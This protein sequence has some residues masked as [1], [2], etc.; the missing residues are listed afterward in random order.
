M[1]R[2]L[3][4][5]LFLSLVLPLAVRADDPSLKSARNLM[6]RGSLEEAATQFETLAKTPANKSAATI[7]LSRCHEFKGRYDQALEVI[8]SALKDSP[9]D[10]PL[11]ARRA[12][13]LYL[14]GRWDDADKAAEAT[15]AI[16][17]QDV[18][19]RWV[20][21][22]LLRDRGK[23]RDADK[24]MA[25]LTRYYN[26]TE[27]IKDSDVLVIIGQAV[28][29]YSRWHKGLAEQ[30]R[31]V[32][33]DL[34]DGALK[35]DKD[36]W[37][38][39]YQAGM[40]LLEKYNRPDALEAFDKALAI[41]P[42][43]PEALVGKGLAAMEKLEL[44]EAENFAERALKVNP[45]LPEALRLIAD[46]HLF[47]GDTTAAMR[48]LETARK[49][50]PRDELTLGRVAA[51]LFLDKKNAEFDA[52]VADVSKNDASPAVFYHELGERLEERRRY[53]DAEK[54]FKKAVELRDT[55]AWPKNS[56]GMLYMRMG[57][58]KEAREI[59][60][61]AFELDPFNVRVSNTLKVLKHLDKYETLKTAHFEMRF[62]PK[63]DNALAHFI[64]GYLE[65]LYDN[66]TKQFGY[67]PKGLILIEIFTSHEM[68]SGRTVALPDLH[69]IGACTGRMFAMVSPEGWYRVSDV[70]TGKR[71]KPFN[72]ARVIDHELV[73]I[74]NLEQTNF[75]VPHWLTEGLAV[76]NEGF[77]RPQPWNTLLLAR[78]PEGKL[79]NLDN[80]DLGFMRPRTPDDWH[81]AYC[82]SNLYVEYLKKNYGEKS[83]GEM[84]AAY[85]DGLA[86]APAI[87]KVCKVDKDTFEKGYRAYLDEVIKGIKTKPPE[88]TL[89]FAQLREA[90]KKDP[91]DL[92]LKARLADAYYSRDKTQ[93]R[94]LAEEVIKDKATQPIALLV[95][96]RLEIAAG[97]SKKAF[98]LL[99]SGLDRNNPEP[100]LLRELGKMYYN[101]SQFDKALEVFELGRK[102]EPYERQWLLE[103]ARVYSQ[104]NDREK[105]IVVL[106]DLVPTDADDFDNRRRL[107]KLLLE[108]GKND[109]AEKYG[110]QAL[111]IDFRD[112]ESQD[113]YEKALRAHGKKAEAD[114]F[115]ELFDK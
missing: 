112:K 39:E 17:K 99:E 18:H 24:E 81:M 80:I 82:Q 34:Y 65:E 27:S 58:E 69:T 28:S 38:A 33:S 45:N 102:A 91:N 53:E 103:L 98:T 75:L 106:K 21:A 56:L 86:T 36:N 13:V 93:A 19:A 88:K 70:G 78:V 84:L 26:E 22:Q 72:W 63:Y 109:E 52:L 48:E 100:K 62:D 60:D 4:A 5:G 15:L 105:Q 29:E 10:V 89:T 32:L 104:T 79:M 49:V 110:R 44:K 85:R 6:L 68:F 16:D 14:R 9:K 97:N 64:A 61:K 43:A 57:Q 92:D 77:P 90:V 54:Y 37:L 1:M 2:T 46:V 3:C 20:R 59:L 51:C 74:F 107:A 95:L 50:N 94:T 12:E 41:N 113:L 108:A 87:Q 66:Y 40:L 35:I 111:E 30:F 47:S 73:H 31:D 11:L 76:M 101:S 83:I 23:L 96:A 71:M 42:T 55:L 115:R 25:W 8:D 67:T 7:G 114:R